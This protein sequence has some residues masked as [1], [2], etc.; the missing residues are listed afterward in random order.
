MDTVSIGSCVGSTLV[1]AGVL[2]T[3]LS[4]YVSIVVSLLAQGLGV[5]NK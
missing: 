2:S 4:M 1:R 5:N 3:G